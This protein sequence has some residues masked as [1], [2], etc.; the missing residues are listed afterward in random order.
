MSVVC[1]PRKAFGNSLSLILRLSA[2]LSLSLV[3]PRG[4]YDWRS[5]RLSEVVAPEAD[6]A[7][8]FQKLVLETFTRLIGRGQSCACITECLADKTLRRLSRRTAP[9]EPALPT[10]LSLATGDVVL[11]CKVLLI[12]GGQAP[13]DLTATLDTF[14]RSKSHQAIRALLQ[15]TEHWR[16]RR[17][18]CT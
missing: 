8:L 13:P 4:E 18:A 1:L 11:L 15:Q 12:L 6:I 3:E 5:P 2:S 10:V 16:K 9:G 17:E 14:Q 7:R